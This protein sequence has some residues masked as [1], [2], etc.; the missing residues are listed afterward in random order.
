MTMITISPNRYPPGSTTERRPDGRVFLW[1]PL[2]V[3]HTVAFVVPACCPTCGRPTEPTA[4]VEEE[5]TI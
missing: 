4:T 1:Y 2:G 3:R 5:L